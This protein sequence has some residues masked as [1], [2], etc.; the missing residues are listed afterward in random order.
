MKFSTSLRTSAWNLPRVKKNIID[1][2]TKGLCLRGRNLTDATERR[3]QTLRGERSRYKCDRRFLTT[4]S[5]LLFILRNLDLIESMRASGGISQAASRRTS[6]VQRVYICPILCNSRVVSRRTFAPAELGSSTSRNPSRPQLARH[7]STV[8]EA[9]SFIAVAGCSRATTSRLFAERIT[10]SRGRIKR[11]PG[12][13]R[14]YTKSVRPH[15]RSARARRR[16]ELLR[17]VY[18]RGS[19]T[20]IDTFFGLAA[21]PER[22]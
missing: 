6:H 8:V 2:K 16:G 15:S 7:V 21:L 9:P 1:L 3:K 12:I 5:T 10:R 4:P 11:S 20:S 19:P 13:I 18:R 22:F 17:K 14:K